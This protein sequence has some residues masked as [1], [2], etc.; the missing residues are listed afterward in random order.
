MTSYIANNGIFRNCRTVYVDRKLALMPY[1]QAGIIEN[2][3]GIHLISYSTLVCTID[4]EGFLSCTGTYSNTTRK[5]INRFLKEVAP[6]VNYY[7]AKYCYEH[8]VKMHVL[9][10]KLRELTA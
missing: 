2:D 3:E 8:S 6:T 1:A 9:S 4:K 5:H 7:D 10:K